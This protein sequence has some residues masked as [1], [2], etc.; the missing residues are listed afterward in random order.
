MNNRYY[1]IGDILWRS[2]QANRTPLTDALLRIIVILAVSL[3][4]LWLLEGLFRVLLRNHRQNEADRNAIRFVF[5]MIRYIVLVISLLIVLRS[6][7]TEISSGEASRLQDM[8]FWLH[9]NTVTLSEYAIKILIALLIFILF[10]VIQNGFFKLVK[11][12]L[13]NRGVKESFSH[14]VLNLVKYILLA[15]LVLI[16]SLQ[17]IITGGDSLIA[18]AI[19]TY[20]CIQIG[21][22]TRE[23]RSFL[24]QKSAAMEL[25]ITTLGRIVTMVLLVAMGFGIYAG[26]R[27]FLT[28]GGKDIS[29][30]LTMDEYEISAQLKTTFDENAALGEALS[31]SASDRI[32]VRSDG[33]LNLIY[34]DDTLIGFNTTGR[35]YQIFGV[36]VNEPEVSAVHGMMYGADG[37]K[38]E[39]KDFS[40]GSSDSHYYYNRIRN[41]CL[42]LTVN[43]ASNRVVSVTYYNDFRRI[44][45]SISLTEE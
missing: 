36:A 10:N 17:L 33:E 45:N 7:I 39:V 25:L 35:K 42:V 41:D 28:S 22:P 13:D 23:I 1:D 21:V 26:V 24:S 16:T 9:G 34:Y 2:V 4:V 32:S 5:S 11:R 40:G 12:H 3:C 6:C 38:R 15:F 44:Q 18:L 29:P 20:I 8:I 43:R 37:S 27:Y 14:L 30:Y 19:Y 31:R